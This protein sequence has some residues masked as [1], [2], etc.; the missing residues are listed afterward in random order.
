MVPFD[1]ILIVNYKLL[2]NLKVSLQDRLSHFLCTDCW[3]TVKSFLEFRTKCFISETLMSNAVYQ[4]IKDDPETD[5]TTNQNGSSLKSDVFELKE[6]SDDKYESTKK[7][8]RNQL[9]QIMNSIPKFYSTKDISSEETKCRLK[10]KSRKCK[11]MK[12][13]VQIDNNKGV[14]KMPCGICKKSYLEQK[15]LF[16]HLESHKNDNLCEVCEETFCDWPEI[17]SHRKMHYNG[18]R[19]ELKC[20]QCQRSYETPKK[21]QKHIWRLHSCKVLICNHCSISFNNKQKLK[22]HLLTHTVNKAYLCDVCGYSCKNNDRLKDHQIRLHAEKKFPC[23]NCKRVFQNQQKHDEHICTQEKKLCPICGT[24][25]NIATSM[26][27][28]LETH[29]EEKR[30]KCDRCPATYKTKTALQVHKDRHDGIRTKHCEYCPAK[31]YSATVLQKHRRIHTGE[32]PYVCKICQKS[33]TGNSNLK[34]HMKVHEYLINKRIKPE[35]SS[36]I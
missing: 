14:V 28:H 35:D 24:K 3:K 11:M 18:V 26:S 33:F 2:T 17:L 29:G 6:E 15:E 4:C 27:R 22:L 21:L 19:L 7:D 8:N 32:R 30:H 36:S 9:E 20:N 13:L 31:F 25:I 5:I 23:K 10:M 16:Q 12:P 34:K 1:D